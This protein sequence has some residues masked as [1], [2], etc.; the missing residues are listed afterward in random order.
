MGILFSCCEPDIDYCHNGHNGHCDDPCRPKYNH[1]YHR[2]H[3]YYDN[4]NNSN[5]TKCGNDF[6][7]QC[8]G[9]YPQQPQHTIYNPSIY[10][11]PPPYN[12]AYLKSTQV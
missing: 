11:N 5:W 3:K 9:Y 1:Y 10:A 12:P 4:E 2:Y 7:C 6:N 8:S